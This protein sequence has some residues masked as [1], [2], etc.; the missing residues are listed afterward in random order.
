MP[1]IACAMTATATSFSP[2]R[3]PC[4]SGPVKLPATLAKANMMT[5][6]GRVKASHAAMPPRRPLPRRIS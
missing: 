6:E 1:Q 3:K 5:A 4:A 2:C